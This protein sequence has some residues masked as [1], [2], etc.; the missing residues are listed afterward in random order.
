MTFEHSELKFEDELIDYLTKIGGD[1]QWTY[2]SE[3][4]A[5]DQLWANF[6]QILEQNN[7]DKLDQPLT[8][9][10]FNQVKVQIKNLSTPYEAGQF[11]YG[12][13]GI[14]QVEVDLDNGNHVFLTVFDQSHIGAGNTVYQVAN[15]IWREPVIVGRKKRR[16]DTTL[17]INGLP[18]I[19]IEE[20]ADAH[21]AKEALN[22]MQ[23]YISENQYSDIFS[24]V[25]ILV[26]LTP[27]DARYM[28]NTTLDKFNTDFAFRWQREKDNHPVYEWREFARQM[29]SIP[30]AHEMATN[31]MILDG[32]KNH[33]NVKV[34]R[35]YQVYATKR[36]L[37]KLRH[38]SFGFDPKEVGYIWHTTGS[39]KTISSFKA[40]WLAARLPNVDKVVFAVDRKALTKQT[41]EQYL[42]YDP[43]ADTAAGG[44]I[45]KTKNHYDLGRQLRSKSNNIIVTSIQKLSSLAS[46]KEVYGSDKNIVF[47]MDEAHRSTAGDMMQKIKAAFPKS[48]FV[49]Y[50]GTPNFDAKKGP[51]TQEI[52]G[53]P[54]HIYTIKDAI[55]DKNVLGFK[56]DFETTL[57]EEVMKN[58]YLPRYFK[59]RYPKFSS[60][61]IEERIT[62]LTPDD[63]DEMVE[64]SV[65]DRNS[66]HVEK[67]VA[68]ILEKWDK[69]S[70][71]GQYNA[72]LTTHVG[73]GSSSEM[74]MMY[75]DEFNKQMATMAKP[76]KVAVTFSQSTSNDDTQ[77]VNNTSLRRAMDNYNSLFNTNF[78]DDQ[79]DDYEQDLMSRLNRSADDRNYLDLVIVVDQLL[80]GFDAPELNTLYVDRT[81][82]G[83]ALIQA[84]SRTNRVHDMQKK[85][86]GRIV[87]YRWPKNAEK[88]MKQALATYADRQS[89]FV[90]EELPEVAATSI[91]AKSYDE[92][93]ES[94]KKTVDELATLTNNFDDIPHSEV[95]QKQMYNTLNNYSHS[96]A[97]IKQDEKYDEEHPEKLLQE[98]GMSEDDEAKLTGAFTSQIKECVAKSRHLDVSDL[99]LEMEHIKDI[100]VDYDYLDEL[101]AQLANQVNDEQMTEAAKTK[102]QIENLSAQLDDEKYAK[103]VQIVA[104]DLMAHKVDIQK[105]PVLSEE[106]KQLIK[107]HTEKNHRTEILDFKKKWGLVDITDSQRINEL[108]EKHV[109]GQDDLDVEGGLSKIVQEGQQNYQNDAEDAMVRELSK[110]KYHTKLRQSFKKFADQLN[111]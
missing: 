97:R 13:N 1:K 106:V 33:E 5:T 103:D 69:R 23:Q 61:Q 28:A 14:S 81:L 94:L 55:S 93:I 71:K 51:T 34:M 58:Q 87:N 41:F 75:L 89:A 70:N 77:L 16:F 26:A 72:L 52:F 88:L 43:T 73:Q 109:V 17:L 80:T 82:K 100:D 30:M 36:I 105:Y 85:P 10:E 86:F 76:L 53:D 40:A 57:S 31:F 59:C 90:Q 110:I 84:Y 35:P 91:L 99:T 67:V 21:D 32:T 24:T 63:M 7:Q 108:L 111:K 104:N 48:A 56:V 8:N 25:Q 20:K 19:Q 107:N 12:I 42:A 66:R 44:S 65:Y 62:N 11:L 74:A 101:I 47:I 60:A 78:T 64:P 92:E 6:K 38:H 22:Q 49:G 96:M 29:L 79:V 15:Q 45:S 46:H 4:K 39:G 2:M 50:T 54:L 83:S 27:H 95:K 18:I 37:E 68:D 102:L 98:L 3:I 9:N